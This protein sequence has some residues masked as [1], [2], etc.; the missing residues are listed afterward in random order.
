MSPANSLSSPLSSHSFHHQTP[1][2]LSPKC[3]AQVSLSFTLCHH[4]AQCDSHRDSWKSLQWYYSLSLASYHSPQTARVGFG[5]HRSGARFHDFKPCCVFP[6]V[7]LSG[8]SLTSPCLGPNLLGL[9]SAPLLGSVL[10]YLRPCMPVISCLLQ[11]L[12]LTIPF[13]SSVLSFHLWNEVLRIYYVPDT[14]EELRI[15]VWR[16]QNPVPQILYSNRGYWHETNSPQ[17]MLITIVISARKL[18][19]RNILENKTGVLI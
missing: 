16:K 7:A 13:Y 6:L 1:S 14:A 11:P 15:Q 2:G 12:C 9:P 3:L 10:F 4:P 5:K 8:P 17:M 18:K 19:Y